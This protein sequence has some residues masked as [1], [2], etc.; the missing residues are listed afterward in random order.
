[1]N[2]N[3]NNTSTIK[4]I[5]M[6]EV[7][8]NDIINIANEQNKSQSQIIND[9]LKAYRDSYYMQSKAVILNDNVINMVNAICQ[10]FLDEVNNKANKIAY[11]NAIQLGIIAQAMAD[12][13]SI[14]PEQFDIYRGKSVEFFK[15]KKKGITLKDAFFE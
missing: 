5:R 6:S 8:S 11:E 3:T 2:K 9:A 14:S 7:L 4:Y 15:I 12:N 10:R 13:L 1:M